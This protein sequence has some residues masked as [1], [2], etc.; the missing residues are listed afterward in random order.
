LWG[1]ARIVHNMGAGEETPDVARLSHQRE[2]ELVALAQSGDSEARKT[3]VLE[4]AAFVHWIARRHQTPAAPLDDLIQEGRIG[5]LRAIEKFDLTRATRLTTFAGPWIEGEVRRAVREANLVQIPAEKAIALTKLGEA[6]QRLRRT[7]GRDPELGELADELGMTTADILE[8]GSLTRAFVA[9]LVEVSRDP[10][11]APEPDHE[12]SEYST[13]EV[14]ALLETYAE[15][16]GRREGTPPRESRLTPAKRR[17]VPTSSGLDAR[18][19]DIDDALRRLPDDQF[20]VVEVRS[21]Y[22]LRTAEAA[23]W[24]GVHPNTVR[25]RYN[26]AVG[27]IVGHLNGDAPLPIRRSSSWH[28]E[29]GAVE[30]LKLVIRTYEPVLQYIGALAAEGDV[31]LREM[32][33]GWVLQD[34]QWNLLVSRDIRETA[35]Q[36]RQE[37]RSLSEITPDEG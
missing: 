27:A 17:T 11:A 1:L 20:E 30:S 7:L 24:L 3:L 32:E 15:Q 22:G 35:R 12:S 29:L 19:L 23:D 26:A 31:F 21:L 18:L 4:F 6:E 14:E 2:R 5:L 28:D 9:D 16:R 13:D 25:N 33:I 37:T 36:M 34:D 8:V 10:G